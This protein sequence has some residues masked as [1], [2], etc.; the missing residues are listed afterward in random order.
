M[1]KTRHLIDATPGDSFCFAFESFE[2]I[3]YRNALFFLRI[4]LTDKISDFEFT[5][6]GS[7]QLQSIK[8][9]IVAN[10]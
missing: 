6:N 7:E 8:Y 9:D 5:E 1:Q 10:K 2:D 3:Q 4:A